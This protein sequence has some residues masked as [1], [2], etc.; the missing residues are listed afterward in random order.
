MSAPEPAAST[1]P[2]GVAPPVGYRIPSLSYRILAGG[3]RLIP[4]LLFLVAL[5]VG[6]LAFLS[7]HG[8]AP[9]VPIE[10]VELFG[11][12]I[13]ILVT[14]RYILRPTGAY[15]PLSIT[16]SAVGLLYLYLLYLAASYRISIGNSGV[17]ISIG[18]SELIL[19]LMIAPALALVAGALTTYEDAAHPGE[20]LPFD[21][22]A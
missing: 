15:G 6:I 3:L 20:R 18:Y 14:L 4:A 13:A 19:L 1:L 16:T 10:T 17:G 2:S 21:Y 11:I 7:A 8:I 9:P 5:P 22:P 12:A